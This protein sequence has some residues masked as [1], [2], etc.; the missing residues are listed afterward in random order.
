MRAKSFSVG[1]VI[2]FLCVL[3]IF[4]QAEK[5]GASPAW[6]K[7][8]SN[9]RFVIEVFNDYQCPTCAAFN[10]KLKAIRNKYPNDILLI[11]RHFPLI[12]VH[13]KAMLA[14]QATEA[15]GKQDKFWEMGEL[16]LERQMSW[17]SAENAEKF[18]V[19]YAKELGLD[20]V[21]FKEDLNSPDVKERINLDIERARSLDLNSTPS[22]LLNGKILSFVKIAD[23]EQTLF[24]NEPEDN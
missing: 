6:Q 11:F 17:S 2:Y 24:S 14:S 19:K 18:F 1:I 3:T 23:L 8:T 4:A 13:D 15:A 10:E 16:L 20:I 21:K 5:N 12:Q 22:V 9:A 7:G